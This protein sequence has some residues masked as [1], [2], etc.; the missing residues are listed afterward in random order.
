M[1]RL[2]EKVK[3]DPLI[4]KGLFSNLVSDQI[5]SDTDRENIRNPCQDE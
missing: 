1:C 3:S 2:T 4:C 5:L